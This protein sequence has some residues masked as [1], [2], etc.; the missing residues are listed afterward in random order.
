MVCQ[1]VICS[2]MFEVSELYKKMVES[3][4]IEPRCGGCDGSHNEGEDDG[5]N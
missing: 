4:K 2:R 3:G 1:C 5:K